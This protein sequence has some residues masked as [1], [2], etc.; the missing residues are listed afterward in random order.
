M[1]QPFIKTI[2]LCLA[3]IF[4]IILNV[5]GQKYTVDVIRL[6]NGDVYKGIV[7]EQPDPGVLKIE[8]LCQNIMHFNRKDV[9]SITSEKFKPYSSAIPSSF[10]PKG[11]LNIT[12]FGMLIGTGNNSKNA[13]LSISSFNGYGFS[14][15]YI[16]GAG[17][18]VE[19][20]ET[21]I[22]PM[23]FET[24]WIIANNKFTPFLNLKAGYSLAL[25]DPVSYWGENYNST[26]G[27]LYGTGIGVLIWTNNRNA[28][29]INF[30][31]RYQ[32][33]KTVRT[34]EW[35][36]ETTTLTTKYNRLEL[37]FGFLFQ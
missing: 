13:I 35:S 10:G 32:D 16:V 9:E 24:R 12:D 17:I 27:Y 15:R 18:G 26:G 21:I 6:K 31:Y 34:Y 3:M 1:K 36:H 19:L 30:H 11:Y 29:E 7:I 28:F 20:F 37:K 4:F 5:S 25:E 8:T 23:Y 14:S 33:I 22:L 2:F